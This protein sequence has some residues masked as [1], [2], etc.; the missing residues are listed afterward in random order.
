MLHIFV[1][2]QSQDGRST[3]MKGRATTTDIKLELGLHDVEY[4]IV[5]R[6]GSYL[7]HLAR[8]PPDRLE[9]A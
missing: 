6:Q 3:W 8:L 7:G 9:Q 1:P 2:R 5:H 4:Y